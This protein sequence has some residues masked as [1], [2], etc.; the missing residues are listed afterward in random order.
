MAVGE[1]R[2]RIRD[3][4]ARRPRRRRATS[5][6]GITKPGRP[7]S[8]IGPGTAT[9]GNVI[10]GMLAG[11][12]P[13][14]FA[15]RSPAPEPDAYSNNGSNGVPS[16]VAGHVG[17]TDQGTGT[18]K[19]ERVSRCTTRHRLFDRPA[20]LAGAAAKHVRARVLHG[21]TRGARQSRSGRVSAAPFERP[22]PDRRGEGGGEGGELGRASSPKPRLHRETGIAT[23]R[24]IACVAYEGD[25]GY[26]AMVAEVEVDQDTG[27][28]TVK[29]IVVS[30]DCGPISN[31]DGLR[32]QIEGGALQGLSRALGEEVTWDDQK[33][34]SVDWSTYHSL[35]L[36]FDCSES[37][38]RAAQPPR[39]A[40][41][42]R[43]RNRPS[44]WSPPPSATR[45][46]TPP[47][48]ASGKFRSRRSASRPR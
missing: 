34:T 5:S 18:I 20:A 42:R 26:A 30:N 45:S 17:G 21:R 1:L 11:F 7:C 13:E 36:G 2:Q 27:K 4:R 46:S 23:G 48:R 33:V 19:S 6:P 39:Q 38:S 12:Q 47:A 41:H 37:R 31:P 28:I 8:E 29:R 22:A 40:G 32:N 25:N 10:T 3:G 9:P 44:R 43:R 16:Y 14:P 35:P 24:G 15:P